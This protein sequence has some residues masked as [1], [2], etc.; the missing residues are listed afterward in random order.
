MIYLRVHPKAK[1]LN[2]IIHNLFYSCS[3]TPRTYEQSMFEGT[4]IRNA[5]KHILSFI[6]EKERRPIVIIR[7]RATIGGRRATYIP[8]T[9]CIPAD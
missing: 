7:I 9:R 2:S 1:I 8:S 5:L 4:L 6:Q 3:W